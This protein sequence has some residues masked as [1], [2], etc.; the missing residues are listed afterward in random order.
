M[1]IT[2]TLLRSTTKNKS[3]YPSAILDSKV[4]W[5]PIFIPHQPLMESGTL[6]G[7]QNTAPSK[8][9]ESLCPHEAYFFFFW[10]RQKIKLNKHIAYSQNN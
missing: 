8:T 4:T 1:N 6:L 3:I 7:L 10:K 5:N 2:D 9:D